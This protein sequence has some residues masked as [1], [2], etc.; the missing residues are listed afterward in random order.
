MAD[1][2]EG[3][4]A[5]PYIAPER[6]A[7]PGVILVEPLVMNGTYC[8]DLTPNNNPEFYGLAKKMSEDAGAKADLAQTVASINKYSPPGVPAEE[9]KKKVDPLQKGAIVPIDT[10]FE[11]DSSVPAYCYERTLLTQLVLAQKGHQTMRVNLRNTPSENAPGLNH[12]LLKVVDGPYIDTN[13]IS[14]RDGQRNI[15]ASIVGQEEELRKKYGSYGEISITQTGD[16]N[17]FSPVKR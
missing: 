10:F 15:S 7:A 3:A 17:V 16:P 9:Y 14:I 5:G 1:T 11:G 4:A 8:L 12:M 2:E 6:R 13:D